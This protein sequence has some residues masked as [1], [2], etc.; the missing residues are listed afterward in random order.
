MI[1]TTTQNIPNAE[2][3]EI[4]G[5][6]RGST[7]KARNIGRD[8]MAGLKNI[9]GGEISEYTI[10]LA[11]S[12]DD[13][14]RRM[15]EDAMRMGADAIVNVRFTTSSVMQGAAEILAYGTAVKLDKTPASRQDLFEK[16]K[17]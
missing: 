15:V 14:A 1:I 17:V 12:R 10:L 4:L 16:R 11:E 6:A 13:A 7:V 5:I 9:V 3:I 2:I 8:F